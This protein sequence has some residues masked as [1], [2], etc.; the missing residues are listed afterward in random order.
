[1]STSEASV[2]RLLFLA[3]AAVADVHDL[4]PDARAPQ[5]GR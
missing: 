1:M 3:D 4:P 5:R 2:G